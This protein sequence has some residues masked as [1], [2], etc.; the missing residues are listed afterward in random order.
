MSAGAAGDR[1]IRFAR[2]MED[3]GTACSVAIFLCVEVL[4]GSVGVPMRY[5]RGNSNRRPSCEITYAN[6]IGSLGS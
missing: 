5:L 6:L 1:S 4:N 2:L 3:L